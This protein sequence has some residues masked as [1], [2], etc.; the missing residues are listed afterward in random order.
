MSPAAAVAAVALTPEEI[1]QRKQHKKKVLRVVAA[2]NAKPKTFLAVAHENGLLLPPPQTTDSKVG[3]QD[4]EGARDLEVPLPVQVPSERKQIEPVLPA[5][6]VTVEA[7][8]GASTGPLDPERE[9]AADASSSI[10]NDAKGATE[11]LA[12][13]E[14]GPKDDDF[15]ACP[16]EVA[17]FFRNAPG[18]DAAV[19]G[20]WISE[21][22]ACCLQIS[23][24]PRIA[25]AEG[26]RR[27]AFVD[28]LSSFFVLRVWLFAKTLR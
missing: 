16:V 24:T 9:A 15:P 22:G 3:G 21:P 26:R 28:P 7:G 17:R 14:K 6:A 20:D 4:E 25:A 8:S 27:C 10:S 19:L 1:Y 18:V 13:D 23:E 11:V 2:F 12:L 5:A